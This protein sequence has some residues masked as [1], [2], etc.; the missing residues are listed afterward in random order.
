MSIGA[1][2]NEAMEEIGTAI[3]IVRDSGNITGEYVI[4][5]PNA[6]VTKPFIREFFLEAKL[7]YNSEAVAGD[8]IDFNV[9]SD[10]YLVMNYTPLLFENTVYWQDTVL[11]KTNITATIY[12]PTETR[13]NYRTRTIW[14]VVKSGLKLLL[15]SP[16]YGHDLETDEQL[17]LLGIENH[18]MYIPESI[19]LQPL[20]RVWL[21][22]GE[23]FRVE[24]ITKRRYENVDVVKLGEDTR[25]WTTTTTTTTSSSTTTT[26]A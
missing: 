18:E 17:G 23:Y 11:Y 25:V 9:T 4:T 2:I 26:T 19:G 10:R 24:T 8:F 16:L 5:K 15:T 13:E 22:T 6:Q 14:T 3:T 12:R 7:Q 21:T 1:D 20:D